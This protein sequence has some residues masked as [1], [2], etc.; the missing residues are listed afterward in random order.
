M[1]APGRFL[2]ASVS[3]DNR[4]AAFDAISY[5]V[6]HGHRSVA[7]FGAGGALSSS[8]CRK[9]GYREAMQYAG[10]FVDEANVIEEGFS[11]HAGMRAAKRLLQS[12]KTLPDAVFCIS[13]SSAV[14]AVRAF[15]EAG[16]RVPDDISVMGF[17]NALLSEAYLP[18][19]TTVKQPR[20]EIG[21]KSA[22]LL[23]SAIQGEDNR[24][25]KIVLSHELIER[26]R[27]SRE[28]YKESVT[29]EKV[30]IGIIG[31]GGIANGKHLPALK[32]IKEAE[33]VAFCDIIEEK[34]VKAAKEYGTPD[35]KVYTDYKELLKDESIDAVHV[36]TAEPLAQL[37][38]D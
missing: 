10:L 24:A 29:M 28:I 19:I 35:A 21:Y 30:R 17:D 23:L 13:D 25:Q 14:G 38:L 33:L 8:I 37:H 7:F 18:S 9:E 16:I 26:N 22:E 15:A 2:A 5:L 20:Y 3:I 32:K 1:R 36:L 12:G 6:A 27:S 34:A 11:I 31:C 4:K